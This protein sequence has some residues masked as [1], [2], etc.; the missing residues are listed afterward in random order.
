MFPRMNLYMRAFGWREGIALW[1][2]EKKVGSDERIVRRLSRHTGGQVTLRL[3]TSD[4]NA[5]VQ[6]FVEEEYRLPQ[7]IRPRSV[8]DGGANVGYTALYLAKAYPEIE[9]IIAVEPES[10]NFSLLRE[11]V[12]GLSNVVAIQAALTDRSGP[13][14]IMDPGLGKWGF[15][16]ELITNGED[17]FEDSF[18]VKGLTLAELMKAEDLER[19]DLVKIDIEGGEKELFEGDTSWLG[20]VEALAVELHDRLKPG[21][22]RAFFGKLNEFPNELHRKETVYAWR[23]PTEALPSVLP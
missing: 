16:V 8:I 22:A 4:V 6:V 20:S 23:T 18:I 17:S 19:V 14:K 13:I 7:S 11:N 2:L 9:K 10:S 1:L 12:D 15:Q 21:C 5:Y 3:N